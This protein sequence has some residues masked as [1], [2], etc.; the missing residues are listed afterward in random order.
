M[1]KTR[2]AKK[3]QLR[4]TKRKADNAYTNGLAVTL[5]DYGRPDDAQALA[6]AILQLNGVDRVDFHDVAHELLSEIDLAY[7]MREAAK[8]LWCGAADPDDSREWL[9]GLTR[10]ELLQEHIRTLTIAQEAYSLLSTAIDPDSYA[11]PG[12]GEPEVDPD[13]KVERRALFVALMRCVQTWRR[14]TM[15][16]ARVLDGRMKEAEALLR[17]V[18]PSVEIRRFKMQDRKRLAAFK[19]SLES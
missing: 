18:A 16:A 3:V 1:R 8:V 12:S 2:R 13:I 4:P 5:D 11:A 17:S 7:A 15:G 14:G 9:E 6:D 10:A 19:Q